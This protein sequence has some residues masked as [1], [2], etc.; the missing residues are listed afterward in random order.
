MYLLTDEI[1]QPKIDYV[2]RQYI[3][4]EINY[5]RKHDSRTDKVMKELLSSMYLLWQHGRNKQTMRVG[6]NLAVFNAF[7]HRLRLCL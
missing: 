4:A 2:W 6:W 5:G 1:I 7:N 3:E